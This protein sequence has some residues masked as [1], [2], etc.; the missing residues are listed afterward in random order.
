MKTFKKLLRGDCKNEL[1]VQVLIAAAPM[2]PSN[3]MNGHECCF[4][5]QQ[6]GATAGAAA[7]YW[8][9]APA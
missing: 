2:L 9:D 4:C 3:A 8:V 1:V 7:G 6:T 5:R